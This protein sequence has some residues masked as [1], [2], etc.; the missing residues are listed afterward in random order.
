MKALLKEAAKRYD[1]IVIDSPPTTAVADAS[2]LSSQADGVVL[3]VRAFSTDRD[4]AR[5]TKET[6]EGACA[7]ILGVVVNDVDA[8]RNGKYYGYRGAYG[9]YGDDGAETAET[10]SGGAAAP[11]EAEGPA[12]PGPRGGGN[13]D[14]GNRDGGN[15]D[16]GGPSPDAPLTGRQSQDLI[17]LHRGAGGD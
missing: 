4:L 10:G 12:G 1:R 6:I 7:R 5:R 9:H 14:G 11:G 15:G 8:S 17:L 2:V 3:V 13:G 16:G